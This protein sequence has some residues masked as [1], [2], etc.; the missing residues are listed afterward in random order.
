MMRARSVHTIM[1]ILFCLAGAAAPAEQDVKAPELES[2]KLPTSVVLTTNPAIEV[3]F[4]A[5]DDASGVSYVEMV[6]ID[7]SGTFRRSGSVKIP[8]ARSVAGS[9]RIA[10]PRFSVG[11]TWTLSQVFLS[12]AAGNTAVLDETR[13]KQMGLLTRIEVT[14]SSD[15]TSPKLIE[16]DLQPVAI[17]TTL[18]GANVT[19]SYATTDEG[20]GVSH[21]E[22]A[23]VSPSGMVQRGSAS[24][25]PQQSASGSTQIRFPRYAEPG[26]WTVK[27]VFLSDAAGNT[28]VFGEETLP[29][30]DR[31]TLEVKSSRDETPPRLTS[32]DFSSGTIDTGSGAVTLEVRLAASDDVSGLRFL[33]VVFENPASTITCRG[34]LELAADL[35][36]TEQVVG[37]VFP[38]ASQPGHWKVQ[39]VFLADAA[40]NTQVIGADE[41]TAFTSGKTVEVVNGK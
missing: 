16:L 35:L 11:G 19:V 13:L 7:P 40:G 2:V 9:I 28:A 14:A 38:R 37:V 5:S 32:L 8:A 21:I 15:T 6:L 33:E 20:S 29:A 31:R 24:F 25:P 34:R 26:Q 36:K 17:D 4:E 30:G 22:I 10:F 39:S 41:I 3:P 1:G 23:L 18:D 27:S 12:D